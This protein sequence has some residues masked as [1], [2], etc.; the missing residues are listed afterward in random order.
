[1]SGH[2]KWSTIKRKKEA[3]DAARGK[4]FSKLARA[5]FVAVKTGGGPDPAANYKL[6]DV[7]DAARAANM[8]KANIERA[9]S[10]G[11]RGEALAEFTY[12][13]FGPEGVSV[14][15]EGATD[16]KNRTGQE[17]KGIFDRGR[18]GLA[19]PGAVSYNFEPKGL[20]LVEKMGKG[21]EQMLKLID[22]G[23]E[24][25]EETEDGIEIYVAPDKLSNVRDKIGS[26]GFKIVS[27]ELYQKPR[28][29]RLISDKNKASKVLSFLEAL[30]EH[31]DVQ[32]VYANIDVPDEVLESIKHQTLPE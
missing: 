3:T 2:S 10:K 32:K 20:L 27:S 17:I 21:E 23:A 5:I 13:G 22:L 19:G 12:E 31:E 8:P 29:Y 11:S 7:I 15:V 6:R 30:E 9:L 4:L 25:V 1:M 24:D 26:S 14:I 16:N 28:T 18:G